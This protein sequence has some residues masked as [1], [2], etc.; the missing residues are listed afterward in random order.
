MNSLQLKKEP[1]AGGLPVCGV[2]ELQSDPLIPDPAI[3]DI[4]HTGRP[5][6]ALASQSHLAITDKL[7]F[8]GFV[9]T[10]TLFH[11]SVIARIGCNRC[12]CAGPGSPE[13]SLAM[14]A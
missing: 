1:L 8:V 10:D 7:N 6:K 5:K 9:I 13:W 12:F 3:P 2:C 4:R 14:A 11:M